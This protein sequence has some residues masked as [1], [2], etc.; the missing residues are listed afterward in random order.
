MG[1]NN[2]IIQPVWCSYLL[3]YG[4]QEVLKPSTPHFS[5]RKFAYQSRTI[6]GQSRLEFD[7]ESGIWRVLIVEIPRSMLRQ[8][9]SDRLT[10]S[11]ESAT[12]KWISITG[13]PEL[14]GRRTGQMNHEL[15]IPGR[16]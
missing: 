8:T 3:F 1:F 15:N 2:P 7:T 12:S 4:S 5:S 10:A 9:I 11:V 6:C 16:S 13:K 14:A